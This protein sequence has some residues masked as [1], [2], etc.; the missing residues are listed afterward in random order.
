VS[1]ELAFETYCLALEAV[2]GLPL[3]RVLATGDGDKATAL[4]K[5]WLCSADGH[6]TV[7]VT[8]AAVILF[9][10]LVTTL[11]EKLTVTPNDPTTS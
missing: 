7:T 1:A 2:T 9:E 11:L 8:L 6:T 4:A 3:K 5:H 10:A